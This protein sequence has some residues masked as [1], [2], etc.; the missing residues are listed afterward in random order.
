M[1]LVTAAGMLLSPGCHLAPALA[2]VP[3]LR[4]AS[5]SDYVI[6]VEFDHS[7]D[8][9]VAEDVTHYAVAL[10]ASPATEVEILS[11][12]VIDTLTGRTVELVLPAGLPD[13][14]AC[15]TRNS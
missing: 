3:M 15:V 4:V 12:T 1:G 2:P 14:T 6:H 5:A 8:R 7:L 11:A 10:A 9:A 13:S